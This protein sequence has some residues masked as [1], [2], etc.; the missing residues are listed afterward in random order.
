MKEPELEEEDLR[1]F[2]HGRRLDIVRRS[3]SAATPSVIVTS[4]SGET[5]EV[6]LVGQGAGRAVGSLAVEEPGLYRLSDG[7]RAAV[8]AVGT[9][10]PLEYADMRA[11][12]DL[13]KPLAEATGG[14]V[15]WIKAGLPEI[16][17][18]RPSRDAQGRGWIGLRANGDYVVTGVKQLPLLPALAVLILL[19][20]GLVG[21]WRREGR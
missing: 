11:T 16:R 18:V 19:L 12:P 2:A 17:K 4:P 20:G 1:A 8:A 6:R 13:L 9:L 14:A 15:R 3:L 7:L 10:N 21:A 5:Q